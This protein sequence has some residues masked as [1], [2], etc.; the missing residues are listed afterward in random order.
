MLSNVIEKKTDKKYITRTLA[1]EFNL[2]F[3]LFSII[4]VIVS[5]FTLYKD[6]FLYS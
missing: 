6:I 3:F 1:V 4:I 2:M 5:F